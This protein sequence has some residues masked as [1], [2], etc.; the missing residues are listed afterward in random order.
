MK[1]SWR[2]LVLSGKLSESGE[3]GTDYHTGYADKTRAAT[4]RFPFLIL[5]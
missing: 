1:E 2:S 5:K 3:Q 4:R